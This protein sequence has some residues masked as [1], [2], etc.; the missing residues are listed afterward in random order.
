MTAF[1]AN[2]NSNQAGILQGSHSQETK[3]AIEH[4]SELDIDTQLPSDIDM[5]RHDGTPVPANASS[6]LGPRDREVNAN[7]LLVGGLVLDL[8]GQA[9]PYDTDMTLSSTGP[10]NNTIQNTFENALLDRDFERKLRARQHVY[11]D[12]R[13]KD[14]IRT[15]LKRE[16]DIATVNALLKSD[17]T[18]IPTMKFV[19]D[20]HS[21][22]YNDG[23][24]DT[25]DSVQTLLND[26]L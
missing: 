18:L 6:C 17:S 12:R 21:H 23:W 22:S 16:G 15:H 7:P 10:I 5:N 25:T 13:L 14:K 24:L 11:L 2:H 26:E 1:L 4:N 3:P 19:L 8:A 20:I 9:S